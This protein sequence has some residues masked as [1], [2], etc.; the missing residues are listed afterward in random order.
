MMLIID[1]CTYW[2]RFKPWLLSELLLLSADRIRFCRVWLCLSYWMV[3]YFWR[4]STT[5]LRL[6]MTPICCWMVS[7]LFWFYMCTWKE[8]S[9]TF[10]FSCASLS[11]SSLRPSRS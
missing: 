6:M 9:C 11:L 7:L 3:C 5:D 10:L 1:C 4:V 8:S 2:L